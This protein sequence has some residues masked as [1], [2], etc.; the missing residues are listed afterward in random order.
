MLTCLLDHHGELGLPS[1][2]LGR[3]LKL[4]VYFS[5]TFLDALENLPPHGRDSLIGSPGAIPPASLY[6]ADG[7]SELRGG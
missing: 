7:P 4:T 1:S 5:G 6:N 3:G 2:V